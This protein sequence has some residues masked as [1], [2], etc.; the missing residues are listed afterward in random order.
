MKRRIVP[1]MP[2]TRTRPMGPRPSMP[3]PPPPPVVHLRV[4]RRRFVYI[5]PVKIG[6]FVPERRTVQVKLTRKDL[7]KKLGTRY[8][9]VSID[10]FPALGLRYGEAQAGIDKDD[11]SM[12]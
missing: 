6:R 7:I 3:P 5:G 8:L 9:E 4:C 1:R 11:E 12:L 10:E 2:P